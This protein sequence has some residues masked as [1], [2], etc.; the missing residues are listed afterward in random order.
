MTDT[1]STASALTALRGRVRRLP[2][3]T[4]KQQA[5]LLAAQLANAVPAVMIARQLEIMEGGR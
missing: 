2:E 4:E 5:E 1:E 3:G